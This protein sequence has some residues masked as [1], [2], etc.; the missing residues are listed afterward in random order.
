MESKL[1]L[2][3]LPIALT[4]AIITT[5]IPAAINP[6]SIAV[7]PDSSLRK[8]LTFDMERTPSL[9]VSRT[10]AWGWFRRRSERR[11]T[12]VGVSDTPSLCA[13][14]LYAPVFRIYGMDIVVSR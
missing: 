3:V 12:Y 4:V 9:V 14:R 11:L 5:E 13:A 7:A 6:Y 2:R 8:A 10:V 1:D